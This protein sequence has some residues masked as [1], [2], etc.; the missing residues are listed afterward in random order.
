MIEFVSPQAHAEFEP[1]SFQV[2]TQRSFPLA[3]SLVS[4]KE[5]AWLANF[6]KHD[7]AYSQ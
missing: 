6:A 5:A 7:S 3:S 1:L 2:L 4:K